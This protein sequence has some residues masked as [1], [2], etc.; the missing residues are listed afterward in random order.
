MDLLLDKIKKISPLIGNTP[1]VK[2]DMANIK[3]S[4]KLEYTNLTGSI[5]DRAAYNMLFQGISSDR[6]SRDT[7][8]IESSSGNFAI[9]LATICKQLRLRFIAVIDPNINSMNEAKLHQLCWR[10]VKVE[11]RDVMGGYLLTRIKYVKDFLSENEIAYWPNQYENPDNYLSYYQTL[12][13]EIARDM[14]SLDYLFAAVSSGGTITGLSTRLKEIYTN[15]KVIAVDVEGSVIFGSEPKKREL[16]GIGSSKRPPILDNASIDE[17]MIVSEEEIRKGARDLYATH[18]IYGGASCGAAYHAVSSYFNKR[19]FMTIPR[20]LFICP[21]H[22][23]SYRES[24]Y[25]RPL[26]NDMTQ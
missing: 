14:Q 16:S 22:G 10:V 7:I 1:L 15:I 26:V 11:D 21:D 19:I 24:L 17:V 3:L 12:A 20:V 13:P 5:K 23:R 4:V 18:G 25:E 8:I 2:L 6:I 9:A